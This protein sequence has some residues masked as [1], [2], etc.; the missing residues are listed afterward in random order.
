MINIPRHLHFFGI[1]GTAMGAVAAALRERGFI[2]TG[3]DENVYPPMSTFLQRKGLA[4]AP[5]TGRKTSRTTADVIVVGNAIKRGNPGSGS[6]P[7]SQALL[8]FPAGNAEGIFP[9]RPA[10]PGR[11]R[12]PRQD[13][14]HFA[15]SPGSWR[16]AGLIRAM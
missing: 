8:P 11:D 13:D 15:C 4:S 16:R 5:A 12:H 14:H 3:S 10:Q 2:V 1:C 9:A 7:E 6:G